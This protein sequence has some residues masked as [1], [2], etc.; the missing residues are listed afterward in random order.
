MNLKR[1]SGKN[2]WRILKHNR[3]K[4]NLELYRDHVAEKFHI[5]Y[6]VVDVNMD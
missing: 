6:I 3:L 1:I 2:N 4:P 5:K